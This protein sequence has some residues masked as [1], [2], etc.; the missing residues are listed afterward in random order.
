MKNV[1][2]KRPEQPIRKEYDFGDSV[3]GKYAERYA[4]GTNMVLLDPDVAKDF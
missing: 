1:Q 3:V 4:E 2:K